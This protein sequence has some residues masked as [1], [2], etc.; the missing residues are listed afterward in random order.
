MTMVCHNDVHVRNTTM[1]KR[2]D[3][4]TISVS[5]Q[6]PFLTHEIHSEDTIPM[7]WN[8]NELFYD[9]DMYETKLSACSSLT[10]VHPYDGNVECNAIT[11][12][13]YLM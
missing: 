13:I 1:Q 10:H 6:Q 4:L 2:K 9:R 11:Y 3:F 8:S 12:L 5:R 7:T